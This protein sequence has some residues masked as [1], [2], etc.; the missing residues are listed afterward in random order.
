MNIGFFIYPSAAVNPASN[1]I[2]SQALT[3]KKG[4]EEM[5]HQ[6]GLLSSWSDID[7]GLL[8]IVHLFG[9][10]LWLKGLAGELAGRGRRLVLSPILDTTKPL[11]AYSCA[12][13][14]TSSRLGLVSNPG[15]LREIRPYFS[16]IFVRSAHEESVFVRALGYSPASVRTVRIGC[17]FTPDPNEGSG[18]IERSGI[19]HVS[20]IYQRRKNVARLIAVCEDLEV[21]L[22]LV[23]DLR[24]RED[25]GEIRRLLEASK[26]AQYLGVLN[27]DELVK[28]YA[29][30][31][32]FCLP[33]VY[34]GVGLVALE[35][36]AFGCDVVITQNGGPPDYFGNF[37]RYVNPV[38]TKDIKAKLKIALSHTTQPNLARHVCE[39]HSLR[40]SSRAL[41]SEYRRLIEFGAIK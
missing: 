2:R 26:W 36:A 28:E 41:E 29:K 11:W 13:R 20:S 4:L 3:W 8:D 14:L 23:G 39:N 12:S 34:E 6:V 27:D 1:G 18:K 40:S 9:P 7:L 5:G 24:E 17:R 25:G 31:K 10:G 35:A 37:A 15:L 32:V 19:L 30:A 21:P 38:S 33:S 22:R 16:A